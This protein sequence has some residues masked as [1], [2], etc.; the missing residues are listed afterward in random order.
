MA[1]EVLYALSIKQPW[2]TLVVHQLKTIEVRGWSTRR[3][4]RVLI[5]AGQA[6]DRRPE[7][8]ALLPAELRPWANL[9]GGIVGEADLV[10]CLLYANREVFLADRPRHLNDPSWFRGRR[11]YGFLFANARPC[12]FRPCPG[13][14]FFFPL[15]G[16]ILLQQ[17][18]SSRQ[19]GNTLFQ[20]T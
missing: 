9:C 3:R 12:P 18:G 10:D 4:G 5:H 11:L 8:W 2:A 14:L 19:T 17:S 15:P 16:D 20:A 6:P 1:D 7:G 13:A